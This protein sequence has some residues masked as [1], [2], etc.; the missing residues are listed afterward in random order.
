MQLNIH[1]ILFPY[2]AT[3]KSEALPKEDAHKDT[4]NLKDVVTTIMKSFKNFGSGEPESQNN[5]DKTNR[6]A[7]LTDAR[8]ALLKLMET[9]DDIIPILDK[10]EK[11]IKSVDSY[12]KKPTVISDKP[13][14]GNILFCK[15]FLHPQK[16]C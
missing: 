1:H 6:G 16:L 4:S 13:V 2:S 7:T 12:L 10:K 14:R 15:I 11:E 9:C 8:A 3:T 5:L